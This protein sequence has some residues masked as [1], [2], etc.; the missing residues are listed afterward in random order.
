VRRWVHDNAHKYGLSFPLGNEPW[1]I[2]L[3]E[4]RGGTLHPEAVKRGVMPGVRQGKQVLRA[5]G[6]GG[7]QPGRGAAP[8]PQPGVGSSVAVKPQPTSSPTERQPVTTQQITAGTAPLPGMGSG[9]N[10]QMTADDYGFAASF[11]G[12]DPEL[13]ALLSKAIQGDW[14]AEKFAVEFRKTRWY[15][16]HSAAAREWIALNHNDPQAAKRRLEQTKV[17]V[18]EAAKRMGATVDP[19]EARALAVQILSEGLSPQEITL[20]IGKHVEYREGQPFS[21]EAGQNQDNIRKIAAAY[22]VPLGEAQ[23]GKWVADIGWG[24]KSMEDF[25]NWVKEQAK[26]LYPNLVRQID[27]GLTPEDVAALY[28]TRMAEW[29]ELDPNSIDWAK[30]P[31]VQKALSFKPADAKEPK[32]MALWEFEQEVRRDPRWLKTTNAQ[33]SMMGVTGQVLRDWGLVF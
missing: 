18:T 28:V 4:A 8:A 33:N 11:F 20:R 17:E 5:N 29:L 16:T 22:G 12:S 9:P 14:T 2:E 23:I 24:A 19:N 31:M 26:L 6:S 32:A 13:K 3:V 25:D 7:G 30:D 15:Q 27:A 21:G 1:H 10:G